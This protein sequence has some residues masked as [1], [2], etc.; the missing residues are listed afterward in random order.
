MASKPEKVDPSEFKRVLEKAGW[1]EKDFFAKVTLR[2]IAQRWSDM[3]GPIYASHSEPVDI[4]ND[5]LIVLV[6]HSAYKQELF[7]LKSRILSL[8]K[9]YLGK[10]SFSKIEI[11]IG[12]IQKPSQ[13]QHRAT[14]QKSGLA[15]KEGLIAIAEKESDPAVK[16]RLLELIEYL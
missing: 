5:S 4:V 12:K 6:S 9:R 10:D 11:R 14:V 3:V 2:T 15:G 13:A 8:A 7:F 1:N 16:K